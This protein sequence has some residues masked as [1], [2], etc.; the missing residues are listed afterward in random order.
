MADDMGLGKTLTTLS[1]IVQSLESARVFGHDSV[2]QSDPVS[3][4]LLSGKVVA[5]TT[6]IIVPLS[7]T[8]Q[9]FLWE[10]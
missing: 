2:N 8:F 9:E 7:C 3:Y 4:R 1:S 6:L 5:K 10:Q